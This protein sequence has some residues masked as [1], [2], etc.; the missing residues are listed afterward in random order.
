MDAV[1][2]N[3]DRNVTICSNCVV[4]DVKRYTG[5]IFAHTQKKIFILNIRLPLKCSVS[6]FI[7]L[8]KRKFLENLRSLVLFD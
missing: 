5:C 1:P 8:T 3:Q 6:M 7:C 2:Q 4:L